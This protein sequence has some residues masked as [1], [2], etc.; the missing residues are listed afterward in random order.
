MG[1]KFQ[2]EDTLDKLFE[3]FAIDPDKKEM[4]EKELVAKQSDK[5]EKKDAPK[6]DKM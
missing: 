3:S 4:P 1:L 6:A 2:R 5:V